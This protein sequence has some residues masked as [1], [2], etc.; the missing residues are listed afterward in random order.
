MGAQIFTTP[1]GE[2]M[3]VLPEAEFLAMQETIEDQ[4]DIAAVA[5]FRERLALDE[6]ELIPSGFANRIMDGENKVRVWREYRNFTA[7]ELAGRA[8]ISPAYLSQIESGSRDGSFETIKKIAAAL[9]ISVGDLALVLPRAQPDQH[10]ARN[11]IFANSVVM[12]PQST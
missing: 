7:R 2:R 3:V 1:G 8:E 9:G 6:E 5:A 12:P 4:Q 10:F 11:A